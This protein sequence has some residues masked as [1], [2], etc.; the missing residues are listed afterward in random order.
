MSDT[1]VPK[2][3][4]PKS[5]QEYLHSRPQHWETN[6]IDLALDIQKK[7]DIKVHIVHL[8]TSEGI[9]RINQRK[10]I[11]DKLTVE[12]C[13]HYLFFNA[14]DIP[15]A[16]PI[17]KCA[18]PIR[19][20][21]NNDFLWDYLLNSGFNF[22]S[23]DHSPA[24]PERKQLEQGDFFK[25]WGGISGLQFTLPL[26]YSEGQQRGLALEKLISLLTKNPAK[27]LG[28]EYQ[29]GKLQE[30]FDADITV[31]DDNQEFTITE[32]I[33]H[34]KHKATPYLG[35]TLFGKV[36]HTFVNG[37]HVLKN[38]E[39]NTLTVGKLLLKDND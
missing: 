25:A 3:E 18:P 33:I 22:L 2:V 21:A 32:E 5:Y 8:S 34:H 20:K 7:F 1:N 36:I 14:E 17:Y 4:N 27:F 38:S 23:S 12:T 19:E 6:A 31:W 26:L 16:S 15:D 10:Q 9:E 29:K 13:P 28:L 39:L 37:V 30:G 24:P 11:T 35:Q